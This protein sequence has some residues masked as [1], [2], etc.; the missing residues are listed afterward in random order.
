IEELKGVNAQLISKNSGLAKQLDETRNEL[1]RE[2]SELKSK[3]SLNAKKISDTD[4]QRSWK[5][6]GFLVRQFVDTYV[7]KVISPEYLQLL[8]EQGNLGG[9]SSICAAP[10]AVLQCGATA[11]LVFQSMLWNFLIL[12]VFDFEAEHWAGDLGKKFT[13]IFGRLSKHVIDTSGEN[14][15]SLMEA[16]QEWRFRSVDLF[17]RLEVSINKDRRMSE[18]ATAMMREIA[19]FIPPSTEQ[20]AQT[21]NQDAFDL[22]AA[23]AQ[24]DM[25]LRLSKAYY[26]VIFFNTTPPYFPCH[27]GYPFDATHMEQTSI[28]PR[29][30]QHQ[31]AVHPN[32]DLAI[33][34]GLIKAGNADGTHYHL[35][36]V[37]VKMVVC[38]NINYFIG[39]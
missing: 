29:I 21:M 13:H 35:D 6:I 27:F 26:N 5:H 31:D 33:S 10:N 14:K 39:D 12:N 2:I 37:L 20:Q 7:A 8:D 34:P 18:L 17:C 36:R 28:G 22:I 25:E 3:N 16:L 4:I 1:M 38:C 30:P 15:H 23:V 32:L 19:A 9:I 24:L 11:P